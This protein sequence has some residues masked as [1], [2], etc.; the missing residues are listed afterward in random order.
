MTLREILARL[1]LAFTGIAVAIGIAIAVLPYFSM[2][3]RDAYIDTDLGLVEYTVGDS[4]IFA[5][6]YGTIAPP[7]NPHEILSVH[8]LAWDADGFR[9]PENPSENYS[10]IAL[11]DSYTEASGVAVPWSDILARASGQTVRNLGFRGY[12][13]QEYAFVMEEYGIAENP[14]VVVLGFF[15]GNDIASALP[16]NNEFELPS[17]ARDAITQLTSTDEPWNTDRDNYQYPVNLNLQGE[18]IPVA[19]LNSY[20]NWNNITQDDLRESANIAA[21]RETWQRIDALAGDDTCFII[22]YFPTKSQIYLP[23]VVEE[24][25]DRINIGQVQRIAEPGGEITVAQIEPTYNDLLQRINNTQTVLAEIASS[26]SIPFL[27]LTPA[28]AEA[29]ANGE[30]LYPSYDTHWNQ[31]GHDL[32]GAQINRLIQLNCPNI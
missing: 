1:G 11:G 21:V 2:Q 6:Q 27:D 8:Q 14:D 25:R 26:E 24:D 13:P 7:E 15:G 28:F 17:I 9:I 3:G 19:F 18:L 20:V 12:G 31:A 22:A 16:D 30:M 10:I 32:A 5:A 4:D 29:A 23:Y